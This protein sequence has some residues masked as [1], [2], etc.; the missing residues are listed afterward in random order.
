MNMNICLLNNLHTKKHEE[1]C[2][3]YYWIHE[4]ASRFIHGLLA[5]IVFK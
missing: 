5:A 2:K 4:C 1:I 3:V